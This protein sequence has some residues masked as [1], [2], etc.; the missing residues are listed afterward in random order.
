MHSDEACIQLGGL[1]WY[2]FAP[3]NRFKKN[4][5]TTFKRLNDEY[6]GF[7]N[8]YNQPSVFH[9][10]CPHLGGHLGVNGKVENG[11]ITCPFHGWRYNDT[12][13]CVDIPY[14]DRIPE[15]AKLDALLV[16]VVNK[17]VFVA[18]LENTDNEQNIKL[19]DLSNVL[20]GN[21]QLLHSA[22]ISLQE[23]KHFYP[24][25]QNNSWLLRLNDYSNG[26][27]GVNSN[28]A[29]EKLFVS[30][31]P[32][33]SDGKLLGFFWHQTS[34]KKPSLLKRKRISAQL[35]RHYLRGR[36]CGV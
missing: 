4:K 9:A 31:T 18:K 32:T 35:K 12:G 26:T 34:K 22:E 33:S 21:L 7:L 19:F 28:T 11:E 5:V 14:C 29:N 27:L 16:A 10:Y 3:L 23:Y 6:V 2:Y 36:H 17:S 30:V 25:M 15:R 1:R 24:A 13:Q 20:P 8:R